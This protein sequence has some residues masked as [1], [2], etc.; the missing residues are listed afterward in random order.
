VASLY[1]SSNPAFSATM[2]DDLAYAERRGRV[3][4]VEGTALKALALLV[5]LTATASITWTQ[6]AGGQFNMALIFGG[7]FVGFILAIVTTF[8]MDWA[9]ITA[10]LYAACEGLFLGGISSMFN[11]VPRYQ[12]LPVQAVALTF[13]VMFV[14]LF[15]YGTRI[16]RVTGQLVG[17]IMAATMAIALIYMVGLLLQMFHVTVPFYRSASGLSIAFS[18]IVVA[19]AAFN[20]LIDFHVIETGANAQAPKY[21]EWYGAFGLMVTLIWLYIEILNLLRKL[22][23]RR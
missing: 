1:K 2:W 7:A 3:M 14:M 19:I 16:I 23:D 17:A 20:L 5:I 12:G 21:M 18:V 4:T 13:G 6:V 15:L 8:K 10:P 22:S 11:S 9:P